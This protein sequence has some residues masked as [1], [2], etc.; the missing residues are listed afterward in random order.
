MSYWTTKFWKASAERAIKTAAQ[1]ATLAIGA[2]LIEGTPMLDAL[3]LDYV[4]VGGF[5]LGGAVLSL[6]TSVATAA[7][8]DGS[9]SAT[10]AEV[11]ADDPA[12]G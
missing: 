7:I 12:A 10:D 11:L 8:T 1:S 2:T 5:A 6:L 9:P 4:S 3:S